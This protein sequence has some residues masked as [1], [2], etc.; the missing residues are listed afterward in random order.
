MHR[1]IDA[2]QNNSRHLA[3]ATK[4]KIAEI[5]V[6]GQQ[7]PAILMRTCQHDGIACRR[8]DLGHIDDIVP[9]RAQSRDQGCVHAFINKPA[10][11]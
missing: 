5:F 7:Q 1:R 4:D 8:R 11:G 10:H 2:Q 9:S 3:T 6:F